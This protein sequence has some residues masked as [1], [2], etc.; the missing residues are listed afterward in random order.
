MNPSIKVLL[1]EDEKNDADLIEKELQSSGLPILFKHVESKAEFLKTL[2][3]FEPQLVLSD[4]IV[5]GYSGLEALKE[6]Q[7]RRPLCPFIFISW[8]IHQDSV[9]EALKAGAT[10]HVFKERIGRLTFSVHRALREAKERLALESAHRALKISEEYFRSLIENSSDIITVIDREGKIYYASPSVEKVLGYDSAEFVSRNLFD[11]IHREDHENAKFILNEEGQKNEVSLEFRFQHHDGSWR[12]L[13]AVGKRVLVEDEPRV[14]LNA[15]DVTDRLLEQEALRESIIRHLK[16]QTELQKT[17]QRIIQQERLAA[18]GQMASGIAHDFSNALMPVLGFSEI[19]MSQPESLKDLAKVK[20]YLEMINTSARDAMHI[21]GG[22]RDFY[23]TKEKSEHL[24]VTNINKVVEQAVMLTQPKWKE[25]SR[26]KGLEIEAKLDLK[27]VSDMVANESSLREALTNLI[28]N[29]V[30]A[31]PEGGKIIFRSHEE[32]GYVLLEVS[33]TGEGMP[34]EV[35]ERCFEPFY[36]TKGKGGT[37]LG[38]AMVYGVIRRH[39]GAIDVKSIQGVGTTFLIRLPIKLAKGKEVSAPV[40]TALEMSRKLWVLV[41]DDE[42]MVR[43]VLSEYLKG[44]GHFV[45][46]AGNGVEAL[47]IFKDKKYDL[48]ITDRAMPEMNGDQLAVEIKKISHHTPLV[49]LTGFGELMKAKSEHPDGVDCLLSKP[50]TFEAYRN[51]L[52]RV[53]PHVKNA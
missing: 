30:D 8:E 41:V 42:P 16:T 40:S 32:D 50:L 45:D 37:G 33:D 25:E 11:F 36:S 7:K 21:V 19:L 53:F 1:L 22:L 26:A 47:K 35:R 10:D 34:E 28:F 6:V 51:A 18:I 20:K 12:G 24:I 38:L 31:M 17:Q 27:T 4:Y 44:D 5:Q 2:K 46:T 48:V 15:R 14:I 52:F 39:D 13:E 9:V 29:A 43:E 23:R 3:S 49:M